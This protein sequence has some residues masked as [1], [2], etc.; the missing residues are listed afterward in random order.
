MDA[1]AAAL[2]ATAL[3]QHLKASVW[4]YP[5]INAAHVLGI[6]LLV[7]AVVAMD[8]RLLRV[9]R[10]G[11]AAEAVALLRPVALA[12]FG[13]AA[14]CGMLLFATQAGDYVS[15]AWFGAKMAL[16]AAALLNAGLH[17][18]LRHPRLAAGVSLLLWPAALLSGRMIG[19]S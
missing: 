1:L 2:E 3:A 8:L 16:I 12:G 18:H 11:R 13:I 15:N 5:L 9:T 6:A 14:A 7:G 19:Y 10:A 4:T 17:R